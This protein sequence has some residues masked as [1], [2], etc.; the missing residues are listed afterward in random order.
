MPAISDRLLSWGD[1]EEDF[2]DG[3][4]L[5]GNGAS[6]SVFADFGYTSLYDTSMS[7]DIDHPLTASDKKLFASLETRNFEEV[8]RALTTALV[9]GEALKQDVTRFRE[10]YESIQLALV[11]AVAKVHLEWSWIRD[12]VLIAIRQELLNYD[13][14]YST[15]YDLLIYW[16]MGAH[17]FSGFVDY[18]WNPDHSFDITNTEVFGKVTKVLWLH[19]G[20]HLIRFPDGTTVK[21]RK[22]MFNLL[23]KFRTDYPTGAIPLF[24]SEGSSRDKLT[25]IYQSDYLSFAYST[26][27]EHA[28]PLVVFGHSLS[29]QD[30]HLVDRMKEWGDR[31]IAIGIRRTSR[32]RS[33]TIISRKARYKK[34]L[35]KANLVFFDALT[36]PL[37]SD[38]LRC[39]RI[40]RRLGE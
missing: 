22:S 13:F 4:L 29:Q 34:L 9:V 26:F 30:R 39:G 37:G 15:N 38:D 7:K 36:H 18:F 21:R 3:G 25:S 2:F 1:L 32:T 35:P 10:R 6:R 14:V 31:D 16:A 19:G 20:L 11:Q 28:G 40:G 17:N 27:A 33:N 12:E 23:E 5:V 8:L 24:I